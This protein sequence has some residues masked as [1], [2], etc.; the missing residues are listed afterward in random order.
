M[1]IVLKK[2]VYV[3]RGHKNKL[4]VVQYSGLVNLMAWLNAR[5][6]RGKPIEPVLRLINRQTHRSLWR[7]N[8][9]P[10]VVVCIPKL[11]FDQ[12][13]LIHVVTSK[14][15]TRTWVSRLFETLS[16][17]ITYQSSKIRCAVNLHT[18][19][20]FLT[21]K[22]DNVENVMSLWPTHIARHCMEC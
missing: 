5:L 6:S 17:L 9:Y 18:T 3:C 1:I 4:R 19:G 15:D 16:R 22:V 13:L 10:Y 7:T 20:R 14:I 2:G 8:R 12:W 21:Q 11:S